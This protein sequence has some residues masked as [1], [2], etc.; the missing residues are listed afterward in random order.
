MVH[1]AGYRATETCV[2]EYLRTFSIFL[3][4]LTGVE[5][6]GGGGWQ[7][8]QSADIIKNY[9]WG[10]LLFHL[11]LSAVHLAGRCQGKDGEMYIHGDGD[12]SRDSGPPCNN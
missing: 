8:I 2:C 10:L 4:N 12:D 3:V 9:F 7:E 1:N 5:E 6:V 11:M